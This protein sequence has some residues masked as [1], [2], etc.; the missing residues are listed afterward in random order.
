ML[1]NCFLGLDNISR[2]KG[3]EYPLMFGADD[4]APPGGPPH[5]GGTCQGCLTWRLL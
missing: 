4:M 1:I 2:D 5:G 3:V